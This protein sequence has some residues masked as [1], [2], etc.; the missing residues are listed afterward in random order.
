MHEK[1][2]KENDFCAITQS[3]GSWKSDIFRPSIVALKAFHQSANVLIFFSTRECTESAP[4]FN[5]VFNQSC[6]ALRRNPK[7]LTNIVSLIFVLSL[8]FELRNS[9]E[10]K[11]AVLLHLLKIVSS[12]IIV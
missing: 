12:Q 1:N 8:S 7:I 5:F 2:Y 4:I 11:T 10:V 3:H 9:R 6:F